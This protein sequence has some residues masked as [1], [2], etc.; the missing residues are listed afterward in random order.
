MESNWMVSLFIGK[1]W[2]FGAG[3]R[4]CVSL[5][6]GSASGSP[7]REWRNRARPFS[8]FWFCVYVIVIVSMR[9]RE[10]ER[11]SVLGCAKAFFLLCKSVCPHACTEEGKPYLSEQHPHTPD[12]PPHPSSSLSHTSSASINRDG[13]RLAV[14][15]LASDLQ[16]SLFPESSPQMREPMS[17]H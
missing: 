17:S 4:S 9:E 3:N 12:P 16:A 10:R 14:L 13:E 15:L 8:F 7:A 1:S 2:R 6:P 11:E 5:P